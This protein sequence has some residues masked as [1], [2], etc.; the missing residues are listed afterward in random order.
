MMIVHT[1]IPVREIGGRICA[2]ISLVPACST[3]HQPLHLVPSFLVRNALSNKTFCL[4]TLR[5]NV[6]P[7]TF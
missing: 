1:F 4:L 6:L 5:K 2:V 3:V 7:P